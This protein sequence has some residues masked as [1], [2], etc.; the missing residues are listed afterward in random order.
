MRTRTRNPI[1]PS[2]PIATSNDSPA[3]PRTAQSGVFGGGGMSVSAFL[4]SAPRARA[5]HQRLNDL[6][7]A[8]RNAESRA[9]SGEWDG[10]NGAILVG[11]YAMLHVRVYHVRPEE[12]AAQVEFRRAASAAKRILS[13]HFRED[14]DAMVEFIKWS[15]KREQKRAEW[16][17][18][19]QRDRGRM[20][21]RFMFAASM[22]TDYRAEMHNEKAR[23][24]A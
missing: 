13:T 7:I 15:W 24:R 17:R 5:T 8:L 16:A 23:G 14:A 22:V 21:W 11:L 20:Q 12:L 9:K 1:P 10:S 19:Q 2:V 6:D 18:Q 4:D 3:A